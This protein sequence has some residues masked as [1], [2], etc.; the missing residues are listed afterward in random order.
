MQDQ[1]ITNHDTPHW[2][3]L[4]AQ[5]KQ[6]VNDALSDYP[7]FLG[8]SFIDGYGGNILMAGENKCFPKTPYC[9]YLVIN[10]RLSNLDRVVD[11]FIDNWKAC[12]TAPVRAMY[13]Q[14]LKESQN[15]FEEE[16]E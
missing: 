13:R 15:G 2:Q 16:S 8:V 6:R 10:A 7:N 5:A 3:E 14:A 12:D 11:Q 1:L 9:G 4:L